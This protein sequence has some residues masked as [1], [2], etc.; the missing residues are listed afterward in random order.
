MKSLLKRFLQDECGQDLTEYTL[1]I[2]FV[3]VAII[4]LAGGFH[5]NIAG[6]TGSTNHVLAE[7]NAAVVS[8]SPAF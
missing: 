8:G 7:A 4:G 3:L 1:L 6:I 5:D 2:V